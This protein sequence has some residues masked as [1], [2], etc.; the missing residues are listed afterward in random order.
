MGEK[1]AAIIGVEAN[2]NKDLRVAHALADATGMSESLHDLGFT[3]D[4]Q[5]LL[6]DDRA[7]KA[8][9]ESRLRDLIFDLRE[10]DTFVLFFAGHGVSQGKDNYL[11]CYDSDIHDLPLTAVALQKLFQWLK[12]SVCEKI[13]IF[14]DACNSGML[15][16]ASMRSVLSNMN[17]K[18]AKEFLAGS[19]HCVCFCSSK[20]FQSSW[21]SQKLGHGIWT[22]HLLRALR[23]EDPEALEKAGFITSSSLQNYLSKNVPV[24]VRK[25]YS[26][27]TQT[28][29]LYGTQS[30]DFLIADLG[31]LIAAREAMGEFDGPMLKQI[32]VAA[33]E[34][35]A[36]RQ[37][38]GFDKKKG[39]FVPTSVSGAA[40]RFIASLTRDDVE[41]DLNGIATATRS[42][43]QY[44]RKQVVVDAESGGGTVIAP[45]F[46]YSVS[47]AL[48]PN[49]TS[50]VAWRRTLRNVSPEMWG[51]EDFDGIF[52]GTF[53][54]LDIEFENAI[55]VEDLIDR[56]EAMRS[57]KIKVH[58]KD[59]DLSK[60]RIS[61][62]G[63]N[64]KIMVKESSMQIVSPNKMSPLALL[65]C[66][67]EAQQRYIDG[68]GGSGLALGLA[69]VKK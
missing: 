1:I 22:Y 66:F 58:Y 8:A 19:E 36:V 20:S 9:V 29:Y 42:A 39:H 40:E 50:Q 25:T 38:A 56:I 30:H 68:S 3:K 67:K 61:I 47:V 62:D 45:G 13:I 27:K 14:L 31:P 28:P 43:L 32:E 5:L 11:L 6:I 18:E 15:I 37:L 63:F 59:N 54:T 21:G 48:D 35:N 60:C 2:R 69:G 33:E 52:A 17:A 10:S 46:E 7:T 26:G 41:A 57:K 53:D 51:D 64:G 44:T 49:D 55:D 65:A 24:T 23:G 12:G 34:S 4:R 16:D